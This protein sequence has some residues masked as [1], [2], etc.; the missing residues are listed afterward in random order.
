MKRSQGFSLV[1]LS[2]VIVIIG[3]VAGSIFMAQT[4]IRSAHLNRMLGEYDSYLKAVSEFQEKYLAY[5]GD[6]ST[7]EDFWGTDPGGCPNTPTNTIQKVATCNGNGDGKIGDSDASAVLSNQREWFRAWQQ[8]AD[9]NMIEGRFTGVAGAG[10]ASEAVPLQN[11]PGSSVT[12]AGWTLHYYQLIGSNTDYWAD[13]Y[14]HVLDFGIMVNGNRTRGP[15]FTPSE[16]LALDIKID[17]GKPGKGI[18]R[19]MRAA[20]QP[21]CTLTD[22]TQDAQTYNSTFTSAACSIMFTVGY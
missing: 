20:V 1:E 9:A 6:M 7:A 15:V 2:V 12:S 11:V 21:N 10:G 19:T 22:T 8:L 14:A 13:Q 16:A 18:V 3:F 4:L 17:D 5:P